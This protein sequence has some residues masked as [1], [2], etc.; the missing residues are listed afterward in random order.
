MSNTARIA[1]GLAALLLILS[2]GTLWASDAAEAARP[3]TAA[4]ITAS[5]PDGAGEAAKEIQQLLGDGRF[6]EAEAKARTLLKDAE[7]DH[8]G[9]SLQAARA[10]DLLVRVLQESG[11]A[12]DPET[13]PLAERAVQIKE[14]RSGPDQPETAASLMALGR[15]LTFTGPIAEAGAP[16]ERAL[17]ILEAR[18]DADEKLLAATLSELGILAYRFG[19]YERAVELYER[20]L[21]IKAKTFGPESLEAATILNN[22]AN[23]SKRLGDTTGARVFYEKALEI[24]IAELGPEHFKVGV[25]YNNFG[26][27]LFWTG[28]VARARKMFEKSLSIFEKELGPEHPFVAN[29]LSNLGV[30]HIHAGELDQ[31]AERFRRSIEIHKKTRGPRHRDVAYNMATLA[32][33]TSLGGGAG[34]ALDMASTAVDMM[35]EAVGPDHLETGLVLSARASVLAAVGRLAEAERDLQDALAL[36]ERKLGADHAIVGETLRNL[37]AI[38]WRRGTIDDALRSALRAEGISRDDFRR[39][40]RSLGQRHALNFEAVRY[41]GNGVAINV[42]R[43]TSD[44]GRRRAYSEAIWDSVI[45]SR[46]LVLDE[47]ATRARLLR[48]R[49]EPE[50]RRMLIELGDA[51]ERLAAATLEALREEEPGEAGES[52]RGLRRDVEQAEAALA[53]RSTAFRGALDRQT[54]DL[55][56]VRSA[57]GPRQA[58]VAFIQYGRWTRGPCDK[59]S[60]ADNCLAGG[61]GSSPG[62]AQELTETNTDPPVEDAYFAFVLNAGGARIRGVDLGSAEEINE[63]VRAWYEEA[64][65]SPPPLAGAGSASEKAYRTAAAELRQAVWEPLVEHMGDPTLVFIVPDGMLNVVSF[66]T[67]PEGTDGYLVESG[68][69]IHY[70]SAERELAGAGQPGAES[71]GLL[72]LGGPDF[73]A[74]HAGIE[75]SSRLILASQRLGD[76]QEA[77]GGGGTFRGQRGPCEG[78]LDPEFAPLPAASAEAEAIASLWRRHLGPSPPAGDSILTL[79]GQAASEELLKRL[80]PGR[81]ILHLATHGFFLQDSCP[82]LSDGLRQASRLPQVL[83]ERLSPV[84]GRDPLMLSGLALAGSNSRTR[85]AWP[86]DSGEDGYLTAA[87]IATLDLTGAEWVV[88]S[89]CRTGLGSVQAGE[90]VLGLRRAFRISGAQTL[91]ASLWD[92]EDTATLRWMKRLYEARLD[93]ARTVD[94]VRS[95]ALAILESRRKSGRTTHPFDWGGFVASGGW[96]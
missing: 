21:Q 11:K 92:V 52:L 36:Q 25:I 13:R 71:R 75:K 88:L 23:A 29:S 60:P 56:R 74:D 5:K 1:L 3:E 83:P 82:S 47:M 48:E 35:R 96:T 4:D 66:A 38:Q 16:L 70:L 95:A 14:R 30:L 90:G 6:E 80:A 31:A 84:L 76:G 43:E 49:R 65:A 72:A 34:K 42:L 63:L 94:A 26:D 54:V 10:L 18:P 19:D 79:T 32:T 33:I 9:D 86:E 50:V 77:A 2:G 81:R 7:D 20:A 15:L 55:E 68:P 58:L 22:L 39:T 57:L 51:R 17:E 73:G 8:G 40:A 67:L 53:H 28:E 61:R 37:A 24:R 89:A 12:R 45:R 87:E 59:A 93:G 64:S 44:P 85:G 46:A 27:L 41:S 69:R 62:A 91:I 78:S